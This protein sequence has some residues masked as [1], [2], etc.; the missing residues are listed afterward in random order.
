M[1]SGLN[2]RGRAVMD[3]VRQV[4]VPVLSGNGYDDGSQV[5]IVVRGVAQ[6]SVDVSR[7]GDRVP[8]HPPTVMSGTAPRVAEH[9]GF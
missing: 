1:L 9:G 6:R 5:L 7:K 4:A 3:L 8:E 2:D